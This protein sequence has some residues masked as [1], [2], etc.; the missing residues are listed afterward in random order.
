GCE[1]GHV[2]DPLALGA[3]PLLVVRLHSLRVL[4]E[5]AELGEPRPGERGVRGQ[6][7]VAA[8]SG[9]ERA[10]RITRFGTA[11]E[12]LLPAEAI[13]HLE[14]VGRPREPPLLELARHRDDALDHRGNVLP[15]G[16]PAPR[17][18]ARAAVGED[19]AGDEQ[20]VLVLRPQLAELVELRREIELSLD[21]RLRAGS[22]DEAFAAL[23]T[24][25][26]AERLRED[27]LPRAGLACDRVQSG[28]ELEV[29]LADE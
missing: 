8:A 10:P 9:L 14:L 16:G 7:L 27:R 21:V 28:R 11:R 15:R 2:A 20:R 23:R 24:E 25:E 4:D 22:A 6:F 1:V 19:A 12:L 26:Q 17:V 29:G 18:R 13:E 3:Q 5:R